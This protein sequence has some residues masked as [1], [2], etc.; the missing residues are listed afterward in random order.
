V[1]PYSIDTHKKN[2]AID[3]E[4]ASLAFPRWS[5]RSVCE[6][7]ALHEHAILLKGE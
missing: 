4:E 6:K 5:D 2:A 7:L 3:T 1:S